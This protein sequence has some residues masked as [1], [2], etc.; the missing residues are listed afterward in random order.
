M[1]YFTT[2]EPSGFLSSV[3]PS[4]PSDKI[5]DLY[6]GDVTMDKSLTENT[7]IYIHGE[8]ERKM[9]FDIP[10]VL[11]GH[12]EDKSVQDAIAVDKDTMEEYLCKLVLS[13]GTDDLGKRRGFFVVNSAVKET[14]QALNSFTN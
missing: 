11:S 12:F 2:T 14:K 13:D 1:I 4:G 5:K 8:L 10:W 6:G 3:N 9:G 7:S